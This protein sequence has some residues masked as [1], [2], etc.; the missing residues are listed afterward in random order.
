MH[1]RHPE[2]NTLHPAPGS[3]CLAAGSG[4]HRGLAALLDELQQVISTEGADTQLVL[5][6]VERLTTEVEG[7]LTYEEEQLIPIL[8]AAT[9]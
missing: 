9:P 3:G 5:S 2:W 8:D 4:G 1:R 7:H 6:E